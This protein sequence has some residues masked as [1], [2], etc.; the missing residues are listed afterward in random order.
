MAK[1][2]V[3]KLDSGELG[4]TP[5]GPGKWLKKLNS[6]GERPGAG[7]LL[8]KV[9]PRGVLER[10]KHELVSEVFILEGALAGEGTLLSAGSYHCLPAGR[11]HGPFRALE[12]GCV[13]F[14]T[15]H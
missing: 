5:I 15:L 10:H 12:K 14:E 7:T 1:G 6:D 3:T 4:W 8:I 13:F 11:E 9:E 2:A